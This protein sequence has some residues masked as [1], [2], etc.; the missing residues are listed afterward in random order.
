MV[1]Y[2]R[3]WCISLMLV[4][5]LWIHKTASGQAAG[6][7]PVPIFEESPLVN[8]LGQ[9]GF[10]SDTADA[11]FRRDALT[12]PDSTFGGLYLGGTA[13]VS[14][15]IKSINI[16]IAVAPVRHFLLRAGYNSNTITYPDDLSI[17][18][19]NDRNNLKRTSIFIG[20]AYKTTFMFPLTF[21]VSLAQ[22]KVANG[23]DFDEK[24][25]Q[26]NAGLSAQLGRLRLGLMVLNANK[27]VAKVN[28][29]PLQDDSLSLPRYVGAEQVSYQYQPVYVFPVTYTFVGKRLFAEIEVAPQASFSKDAKAYNSFPVTLGVGAAFGLR[30]S[31]TYRYVAA[32]SEQSHLPTS[33]W[34]GTVSFV[35]NGIT[36]GYALSKSSFFRTILNHQLFLTYQISR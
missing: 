1:S 29:V 12:I 32:T 20:A 9:N 30:A 36:V 19:G 22:T 23:G 7:Y 3:F 16:A 5:T 26:V 27:A 33:G 18:G 35:K 13:P 31:A 34:A 10:L 25:V 28:Y 15:D 2:Y 11:V 24:F 21:N 8:G 4:C 14:S 6:A 17:V